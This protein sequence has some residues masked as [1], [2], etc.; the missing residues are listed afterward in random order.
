[1]PPSPLP[2]RPPVHRFSHTGRMCEAAS[3][4]LSGWA[5]GAEQWS[6]GTCSNRASLTPP[7]TC[8]RK[9]RE[10]RST[11]CR[12]ECLQRL[13]RRGGR[14]R[15]AVLRAHA[16][17]AYTRMHMRTVLWCCARARRC[18]S[19]GHAH[20]HAHVCAGSW[21]LTSHHPTQSLSP[22]HPSFPLPSTHT[23]PCLTS[24]PP[25]RPAG[26]P[27]SPPSPPSP[28]SPPSPPSPP[29]APSPLNRH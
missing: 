7:P 12:P 15:V 5:W 4:G 24:P 6:T 9:G 22:P 21:E 1:M 18:A 2:P 28:R 26:P 16:R 25:P 27:P 14:P 3:R 23:D 29:S 17:H 8:R 11:W 19:K 10:G 13:H 20:V